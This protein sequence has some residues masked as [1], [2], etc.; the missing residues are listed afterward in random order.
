MPQAPTVAVPKR[1]PLVVRP[2]N[3][4]D[5]T[6]KDSKLVNCYME[7]G[8]EGEYFLI[9]RAGLLESYRPTGE[10]AAGQGIYNWRGN[11]YTVFGGQL[12]KDAVAK[13]A[14]DATNGVYRFSSCLGATP[15]LQ[16]GNGIK[17]YNYDDS[18]GLVLISDIDFPA[19]FVKG[20]SYIDGT[21]YVMTPAARIQGDDINTPT[22]WDPVNVI[23]AQ[24]EPDNGVALAKQLVYVIAFKQWSTEVFYDAANA[25]GSP[26]GTV[27]GAKINMGCVSAD[28]VQDIEGTLCWLAT[29]RQGGVQVAAM[30]DLKMEIVST[31]PI[32]RLLGNADFTLVHSWSLNDVGHRTYIVTIVNS[33]L[34]L[35]YDLDERMWW[36]LTDMNGNYFP[37][38]GMTYNATYQ[39][40]AQHETD[41]WVYLMDQSYV[42]DD[43]ETI[44]CDI[45]PPN[46]DG[47]VRRKKML[48]RLE[49]IA[50]QVAGSLLQIRNNDNDY[51]PASWTNFKTI[52]LAMRNPYLMNEGT[53][54]R[55]AYHFR[56]QSHTRMRLMAIELQ[57]DLG[58]L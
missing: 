26:L 53:F 18:N 22:I 6:I 8:D 5:D 1:L 25:V 7:K 39:H 50:D 31:K 11:I 48:T 57:L 49:V 2:E 56:H 13:G 19:A 45:Y 17:A 42:T 20:W 44:T 4:N 32:E 9:K 16:L 54:Y 58:T 10:A 47:G 24:I 40:L 34:T 28:S 51:D 35:A 27:Q 52:D 15:K 33:N 37:I 43:G 46:F 41:G 14:V 3:R 30:T 29:N 38:V 12:Y 36:Q 55:R 23:V 21:T